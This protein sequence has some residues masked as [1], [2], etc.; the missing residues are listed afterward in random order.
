MLIPDVHLHSVSLVCSSVQDAVRTKSGN[1][2]TMCTPSTK[3][4]SML[5]T[6]IE[7]TI[8]AVELE[9]PPMCNDLSHVVSTPVYLIN[10]H[11]NKIRHGIAA[12]ARRVAHHKDCQP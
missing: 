4:P 1:T 10:M 3:S 9:I 12:A 7:V 5:D 2:I 6:W 11:C 8:S